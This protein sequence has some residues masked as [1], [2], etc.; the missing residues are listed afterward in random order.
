LDDREREEAFD[1]HR[2]LADL[3]C[4]VQFDR[5][6][7]AEYDL[8]KQARQVADLVR[9]GHLAQ[10][11]LS[12]DRLAY[13]APDPEAAQKSTEAWVAEHAGFSTVTTSF[14]DQ[15][16]DLGVGDAEINTMLV[17]NPRRALAF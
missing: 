2:R 3:G 8:P 9:G 1:Y 6:G 14:L 7:L 5:V 11:L 4:F 16:H 12:H 15:L 10:L 13:S 17:E